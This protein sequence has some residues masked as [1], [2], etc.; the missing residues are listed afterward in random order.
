M[1]LSPTL[2]FGYATKIKLRNIFGV[3]ATKEKTLLL[4]VE[5]NPES[6]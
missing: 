3:F 4:V 1:F 2:V 5:R 6:T